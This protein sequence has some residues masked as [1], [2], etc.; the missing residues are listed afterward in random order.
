M[1]WFE[2]ISFWNWSFEDYTHRK[3]L[4]LELH[5]IGS[6]IKSF[7]NKLYPHRILAANRPKRNVFIKLPFLGGT[8]LQ[9]R[10]KVQKLFSDKLMSCNLTIVFTPLVRVKIFVTF[11]DKLFKILLSGLV[12]QYKCGCCNATY[13]GKTKGHF[14]VWICEYLGI[15]HLTEK[16]LKID[17]NKLTVIQ[18][19]FLCCNYYPS[20][21]DFSDLTKESTDFKLKIRESPLIARDKPILNKADSSLPSELF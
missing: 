19:P 11:K 9:V 18:E 15:S 3:E 1:L 4:L 17:S 10:K 2:D 7:L 20:V 16:R 12:Y 13:Y 6:R 5:C 21:E 8:S 14:K